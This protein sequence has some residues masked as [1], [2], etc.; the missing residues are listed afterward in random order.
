MGGDHRLLLPLAGVA[1]ALLTLTAD[2]LGR[3]ILAPVLVP[4]GIVVSFLGVP[5]F[6]HLLLGGRKGGG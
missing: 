4:V 2:T 6:L 5:V 3:L 1:G